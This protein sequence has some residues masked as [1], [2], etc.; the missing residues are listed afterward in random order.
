LA[1]IIL[2]RVTFSG[3]IVTAYRYHDNNRD[4]LDNIRA[5]R[6]HTELK[7]GFA[8]DNRWFSVM[9]LIIEELS[10]QS[11]ADFVTDK[12]L[13]PLRMDRSTFD[14]AVAERM[15]ATPTATLD[16][17]ITTVDLPFW[18]V[19]GQPGNGWQA[20]GGLFS[21]SRDMMKWIS[22]LCRLLQQKGDSSD[23][24]PKIILRATLQEIIRPKTLCRKQFW[25]GEVL[26][27]SE[28][29][30]PAFSTPTYASAVERWHL[31]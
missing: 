31:Q 12:I 24:L 2:L 11:Y 29:H 27:G 10:G 9:G 16:D 25:N 7:G 23:V 13:K 30:D 15:S 8:Y 4:I 14:P 21:T 28:S 18:Q 1:L 22:Y 5:N 26:A 20:P 19:K 3:N 6:C 17:G